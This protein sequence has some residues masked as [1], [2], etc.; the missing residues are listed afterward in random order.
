MLGTKHITQVHLLWTQAFDRVRDLLWPPRCGRC[1]TSIQASQGVCADCWQTIAFIS[2]PQ[3]QSCGRP[4][5]VAEGQG[6][7]CGSCVAEPPPYTAA[8]AVADY[9]S[10]VRE[11]ILALKH[12]DRLD[13]VPTI[14]AW[15]RSVVL[16][17]G[18]DVDMIIPVPL[19]WS[20]LWSRR[21]NQS[22]EISR[23]LSADL[24][25]LH[26]PDAV[27]R[28]KRTRSQGGLTRRQRQKNV[29]SAFKVTAPDLAGRR[30]LIIDDVMTTGATVSALSRVLKKA[31]AVDV[32]VL[33]VARV[34]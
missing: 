1:G 10:G 27:S 24:G 5:E 23:A 11:M 15:M 3:C 22:A 18:W 12:G 2:A 30:I 21:F 28:V 25:V 13:L 19:H 9:D 29:Q 6:N 16:R 4:F 17:E 8:R 34:D 33:T 14:T 31:G 20:R 7:L 26:G 32:Y